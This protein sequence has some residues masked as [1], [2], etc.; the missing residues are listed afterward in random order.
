MRR[1]K[2][3]R[4]ERWGGR[5]E[6]G[7]QGVSRV[8][9]E[10]F[11]GGVRMAREGGKECERGDGLKKEDYY[12][13][14]TFSPAQAGKYINLKAIQDDMIIMIKNAHHFNEPGSEIYKLASTLRKCIINKCSELERKYQTV[15]KTV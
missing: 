4:G 12:V 1:R 7:D 8:D 2:G 6:R 11:K 15:S 3:G 10:G 13:K 14:D 9:L 5:E